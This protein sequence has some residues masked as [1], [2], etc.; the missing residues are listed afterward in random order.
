[1]RRP[2][3]IE[4]GDVDPTPSAEDWDRLSLARAKRAAF[5]TDVYFRE[6]WVDLVEVLGEASAQLRVEGQL[7]EALQPPNAVVNFVHVADEPADLVR[8]LGIF[9][10][11]AERREQLARLREG[12]SGD[13]TTEV[14]AAIVDLERTYPAHD[15]DFERTVARLELARPGPARV[16]DRLRRAAAPGGPKLR[17]D[18]LC[19]LLGAPGEDVGVWDFVCVASSV[20][21]EERPGSPELLPSAGLEEWRAAGAARR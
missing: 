11:R 6:S 13:V 17:W 14:C 12:L 15:F 3:T 21:V 5:A 9:L 10:A 18:S 19:E 16:G 20:L 4:L 1:M 8:E 7:R 2:D